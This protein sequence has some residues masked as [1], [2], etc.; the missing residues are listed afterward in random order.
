MVFVPCVSDKQTMNRYLCLVM[1]V[2]VLKP[3]LAKYVTDIEVK[4]FPSVL[5][6]GNLK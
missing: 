5:I 3:V 4:F 1:T 6:K 2:L